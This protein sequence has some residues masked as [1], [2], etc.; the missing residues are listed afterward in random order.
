MK[1][2][3]PWKWSIRLLIL[4]LSCIV[5]RSISSS[6]VDNKMQNTPLVYQSD[7]HVLGAQKRRK[8]CRWTHFPHFFINIVIEIYNNRLF[9]WQCPHTC[10]VHVCDEWQR[11]QTACALALS[12][13]LSALNKINPSRHELCQFRRPRNRCSHSR[14]ENHKLILLLARRGYTITLPQEQTCWLPERD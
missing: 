11:R 14:I 7:L 8:Q 1:F 10:S 3:R 12:G 2:G 6:N 5:S 9:L 4:R 13:T